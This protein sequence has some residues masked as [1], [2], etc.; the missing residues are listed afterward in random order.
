MPLERRLRLSQKLYPKLANLVS[1]S[2]GSTMIMFAGVFMVL[3]ITVGASLDFAR[4]NSVQ[5]A[6]QRDL[7]AAVLASATKMSENVTAKEIADVYFGDNWRETHQSGKVNVSLSSADNTISATANTPVPMT[8]MKLFGVNEGTAKAV[9]KVSVGGNDVEIA[10]VLDTTGSME[11]QKLVDLKTAANKLID[12]VYQLDG[13]KDHVKV[14]L[15]PFSQYVNVGLA[16]R[17]QSWIDV[18]ADTSSTTHQCYEHKPIIG[19]SNCSMQTGTTSNDGSTSTYQYEVCDY[20]YGPT[21]TKCSDVTTSSKWYGCVGSRNAP[22]NARDEQYSTRI[23]GIMNVTCSDELLPLTN[24]KVAIKARLQSMAA[25]YETYIPAGLIWGWRALSSIAPFDQGAAKSAVTSGDVKKIMVVM[26]DGEN[27]KSKLMDQ[28]KH[29]GTSKSDA[30]A[31]T[32]SLCDKIK[33][34]GIEVFSVAFNVSSSTTL[35]TL[36]GCASDISNF[37]KTG[38]GNELKQAF[39][40]IGYSTRSISLAE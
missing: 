4:L 38:S 39:A 20:E 29:D 1:D 21:E 7:D 27:T 37:F 22:L 10:L 23:P 13:S 26:T 36:E 6:L 35:K 9:S 2:S 14:A 8:L 32:T 30:D 19:K 5:T 11:G 24:D 12:I 33:G 16:N 18:A 15:I 25:K 17:Y 3:A 40:K 34:D 28:P 31:L